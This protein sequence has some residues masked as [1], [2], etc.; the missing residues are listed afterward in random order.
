MWGALSQVS[1]STTPGLH[2]KWHRSG[3][4]RERLGGAQ[5]KPHPR[6]MATEWQRAQP[7]GLGNGRKGQSEL[8][9]TTH[10]WP[11]RSCHP[12]MLLPTASQAQEC[13][14]R[15]HRPY[16]ARGRH[17][18]GPDRTRLVRGAGPADPSLRERLQI[19]DEQIHHR[20]FID[21]TSD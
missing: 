16:M 1:C 5:S 17:T 11:T 9:A 20:R 13:K 12:H 3:P 10:S 18:P 2:N 8:R 7:D 4:R 19:L 15:C 6:G 14:V 21:N